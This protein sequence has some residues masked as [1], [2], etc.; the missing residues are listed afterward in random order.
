MQ[1]LVCFTVLVAACVVATPGDSSAKDT[2]RLCL[3]FRELLDMPRSKGIDRKVLDSSL[4]IGGKEDGY[5][6]YF[7]LDIDGDDINDVVTRSCSP[8][9]MPADPCILEMELSSGAK[10]VFED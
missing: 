9:T 1:R 2:P 8:S 6:R 10:I 4:S 3:E 7:N 5:D